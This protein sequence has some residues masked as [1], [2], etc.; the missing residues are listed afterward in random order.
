MMMHLSLFLLGTMLLA[1]VQS[2]QDM[3]RGVISNEQNVEVHSAR[4]LEYNTPKPIVYSTPPPTPYT[5]PHP[6]YT[7]KGKGGKGKVKGGKGKGQVGKGK[8]SSECS[9]VSPSD[10]KCPGS[11]P[12]VCTCQKK[13]SKSKGKG[14][15]GKGKGS[16][17]KGKGSKGKG[18]GSTGK[19]KGSTGK[20]K[21]IDRPD[22]FGLATNP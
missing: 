20:G 9:I 17:G 4:V 8:G 19:G 18:K 11:G 15:K 1:S 7:G 13:Y 22:D 10:P 14:S 6:S 5:S 12:C 3:I 2:K 21:G 16:K